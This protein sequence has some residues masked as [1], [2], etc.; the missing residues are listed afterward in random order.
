[1]FKKSFIYLFLCILALTKVSAQDDNPFI[2]YDVPSQNLLKF[3]RFLLNPTFST[4]REDKSYFNL[5]HRN[6]SATFNDNAQTYFLSYSGRM[7][8]R[9][10]LGLSLFS[11]QFGAITNYGILANYAYGVKLSDKSNFTFGANVS[12]YRSG[13]DRNRA[14]TVDPDDPLLN[15]LQ[16]SNL[17]SFQPGINLSYGKFDIGVF[18][19]N[20]FDYNLRTNTSITDFAD[21]TFSGHLQYTHQFENDASIFQGGRLMP[22]LRVKKGGEK[23]E[24]AGK[25]FILGGSLIL[26]LPRLGW[27]QGGYDTFFG[28]SAGVGFNLSKR[29]SLGYTMEKGV[30]NNFN[31]FGLTHEISFAYAITPNLTEDRVLFEDD[32]ELVENL[33]EEPKPL[34]SKDEE[35]GKLKQAL[36]E[37]NEIL[38]ELMFRQDSIEA[39]RNDDLE[40]RFDMVMRMV[41]RETNGENP[42]IE[43]KAKQIY[44]LNNQNEQGAGYLASKDNKIEATTTQNKAETI[45][46]FSDEITSNETKSVTSSNSQAALKENNAITKNEKSKTTVKTNIPTQEKDAFTQI[47]KSNN[48]KSRK[49]ANLEGVN[50]GY[51][52]VANVYKNTFYMNKFIDELK[53]KGIEADYFENKK[54][55]L[56]YVYLKQHTSMDDALASYKSNIGDKYKGEM[57]IMN[58]D[59]T[60]TNDNNTAYSVNTQKIKEKSLKY[61]ANDGPKS[62]IAQD[63]VGAITVPQ[64]KNFKFTGV[65]GGYYIIANVFASAKNAN[66]F[67]KLLNAQGLNASYFINPENNYRYVYLKKYGSWNNAL[68]SYYSKINNAYDQKMWIMRIAPS[69]VS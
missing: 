62:I 55:G 31:N 11:Q 4:V 35:I 28:A 57:W 17:L 12:Y 39:N 27:V 19:E 3:N 9:T 37:N 13:F 46:A 42:L 43:E 16:N 21:K 67:V 53:A 69:S 29:L 44:L 32:N 8:D 26:D 40:R 2:T 51:Y 7:N 25:D 47:A 20:L 49:F 66:A 33:L 24:V 65:D 50:H 64:V 63:N 14:T 58:V 54:N 18:A 68:V 38:A 30:A 5:L 1:M 60:P 61:T 52:L 22:L 56:K 34:S 23:Y 6:Q 10:G 36:T 59:N 41:R 45:T 48:V 15:G